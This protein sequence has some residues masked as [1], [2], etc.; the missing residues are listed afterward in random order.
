MAKM[1]PN[2]RPDWQ[3]RSLEAVQAERARR[4]VNAFC[5][6]VMRDP[7]GRPWQQAAFHQQWQASLPEQGP[8]R[9]L[10]VAPRESAKSSQMVVARILWELGRDPELRVKIICSS[11]D[12]A[13]KLLGEIAR[14]ILRNPRLRRVFPRLR[15]DPAGPWTRDQLRLAGLGLSKDPSLEAHG[16][17]SAGVGGRADLLIFDDVCDQRT[18]VLQPA[19]RDQIK[20]VFHETWW[21][22]LGPEGRAVYVAT[23]CPCYAA[24][25]PPRSAFLDHWALH[26]Q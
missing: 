14:N 21:N 11:D 6:Y 13:E 8:A 17:L 22:L 5:E 15:P 4:D 24:M 2:E 18:A 23:T 26:Q 3:R 7:R 16:V 1:V 9:V 25:E 19:M 12:L 20:R 10:I